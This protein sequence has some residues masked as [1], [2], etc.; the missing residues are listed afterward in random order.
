VIR[1]TRQTFFTIS[2]LTVLNGLGKRGGKIN[3]EVLRTQ[4]MPAKKNELPVRI[5]EMPVIHNIS[6]KKGDV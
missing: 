5:N 4:A 3:R 6:P 1:Q 2:S